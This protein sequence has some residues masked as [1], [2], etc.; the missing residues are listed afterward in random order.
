MI[1]GCQQVL[2][3]M[4]S[5]FHFDSTETA[6]YDEWAGE[7]LMGGLGAIVFGVTA[8]GAAYFVRQKSYLA[9]V[10]ALAAGLATTATITTAAD[11]E[12]AARR[13]PDERIAAVLDKFVVPAGWIETKQPTSH[14]STIPTVG[15]VWTSDAGIPQLCDEVADA[16]RVWALAV[17]SDPINESGFVNDG[18]RPGCS[19]RSKGK[20]FKLHAFVTTRDDPFASF[21]DPDDKSVAIGIEVEAST[22]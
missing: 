6:L 17:S 13:H 22:D 14:Q 5:G 21:Y 9:V 15:K 18:T 11:I 8:G 7:P 12:T 19:V 1:K 4:W 2:D 20:R 3:G 10:A 16:T